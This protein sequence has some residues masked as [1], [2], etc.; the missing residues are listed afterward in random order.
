MAENHMQD[1]PSQPQVQHTYTYESSQATIASNGGGAAGA[2]GPGTGGTQ[3][4]DSKHLPA[5]NLVGIEKQLVSRTQQE[6]KT[7]QVKT[8]TKLV[9]TREV[10]HIGPDGQPVD[11]D[12]A[13]GPPSDF[14]Q[15]PPHPGHPVHPG[16]PGFL[17]EGADGSMSY[18]EG[19]PPSPAN[20]DAYYSRPPPPAGPAGAYPASANF[21]EYEYYPSVGGRQSP[22]SVISESPPHSHGGA[23][24]FPP[25]GPPTSGYDELDS[26]LVTPQQR[27]SYYQQGYPGGYLDQRNSYDPYGQAPFDGQPPPPP[28][29]PQAG[30]SGGG[31]VRFRDPD[32]HEVIEFL[33]HPNNVV[34][35]NAAAYLQHLCYMDDN[36]KQ[37]TRALGGIS[38]LIELLAQPFPD[39]QRNACGALRN[40]S[41][42]RRNDENKRAIRNAGGV[43]ALVHLLQSSPDNDIRE[44]VT[45][46]LWNLSSCDELKRPIIDDALRPLVQGVLIP[47]SGWDRA[48]L[49]HNGGAG[50]DSKPAQEIY[51]TAVFRNASGVLR[52]V[53]SAG[54]FARRRLRECEGLPEA[55]LHLVRTAVRKNDMDNKSVENCV[56]ILRNLSYRCQEVQDPEYDKAPPPPQLQDGTGTTGRSGASSVAFKVGESLGCF[57][58]KKK[59]A[60]S[61]SSSE[62]IA[63]HPSSA[64]PSGME[65]LWQADVVQPYLSLLSECSNPETLEAA[66]GA[67]QNLA[68]CYWQPSV[69]IRA[70][71]RKDRGLPVLVELLRMEVDRVVCAVATALRNLAMDQR[72]KELIGKYAMNDLVQKLPNGNPQHDM[73]TSDDTVA[74]VL[75]TLNEV[76]VKNSDF[77]SSLLEAHGVTRLTHI[78]KQKQ[79]FSG[80]VVKFAS[81]LLYNM[82]QHVE[83]REAY[84]SAGWRESHFL[85]RNLGGNGAAGPSTGLGGANYS[86]LSRP[87]SSQG[88]TRYEDRT[89][90]RGAGRELNRHHHNN[91]NSSAGQAAGQGSQGAFRAAPGAQ[92]M[93]L[94]EMHNLSIQDGAPH[95]QPPVGGVPI[96][97]PGPH[98]LAEVHK[99][100]MLAREPVYAQVN[101]EKKLRHR[102]PG[103]GHM[104]PVA[105]LLSQSGHMSPVPGGALNVSHTTLPRDTH[106]ST[107][108]STHQLIPPGTPTPNG[109]HHPHAIQQVV[110]AN[111]GPSVGGDSWV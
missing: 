56:C 108:E 26:T 100:P 14:I 24:M 76:I 83:L 16:H 11:L 71:V 53:S 104:S 87:I 48:S 27:A 78:T 13:A 51:W 8:V 44:L 37:K 25:G 7:Q 75:A 106:P 70:A 92:E 49:S 82:W 1:G 9:K 61:S 90:P 67:I 47:L 107:S 68:A 19:Q 43:P 2:A 17:Q 20:Y 88:G 81:Q 35:S 29:A 34:R 10:R 42:G 22:T 72:N 40:L 36:M 33:S 110:T 58:A 69:D 39:I 21:Q 79:R 99:G 84:K 94:A 50:G 41:Y 86:T 93:P 3:L 6:V 59:K 4:E 101:R 80:R 103:D 85:T 54:E 23:G 63:S 105:H 73:G 77:A 98:Q 12:F 15:Y 91:N 96:F 52:N 95:R 57:G 55:L 109:L 30:E 111:G 74:A 28:A 65:L 97:P 5:A 89:L 32:L 45:C 38:P 18:F 62:Q 46:V 64:S 102:P 31:G 66:A 60:Q